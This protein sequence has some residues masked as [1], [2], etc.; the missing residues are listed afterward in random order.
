MILTLGMEAWQYDSRLQ[1]G[2]G[3]IKVMYR[4]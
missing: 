1:E 3:R 4:L 2:S